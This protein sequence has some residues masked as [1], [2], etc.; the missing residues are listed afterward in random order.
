[1]CRNLVRFTRTANRHAPK[2]Q[3]PKWL[4]GYLVFSPDSNTSCIFNLTFFPSFNTRVSV[5][6]IDWKYKCVAN[7][8]FNWVIVESVQ[9][10]IS[11]IINR[12][13]R[14]VERFLLEYLFYEVVY[15]FHNYLPYHSCVL[16]EEE[17]YNYLSYSSCVLFVEELHNYIRT[18]VAYWL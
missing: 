2:P 11:D 10:I 16:L 4:S 15:T 18:I 5:L 3:R 12:D 14:V 9:R 6:M 1:M 7:L 8:S 13:T 17:L